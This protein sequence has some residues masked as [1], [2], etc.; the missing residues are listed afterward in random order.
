ME[1]DEGVVG[2]CC[3][4]P[5]GPSYHKQQALDLKGDLYRLGSPQPLSGTCMVVKFTGRGKPASSAQC[6]CAR[7][8]NDSAHDTPW[9][10]RQKSSAVVCILKS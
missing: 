4:V 5:G 2:R 9:A 8:R 3:A 1:G 10:L 6:A 7:H